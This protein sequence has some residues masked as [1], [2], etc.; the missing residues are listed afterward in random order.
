[1]NIVVNTL[2]RFQIA[3]EQGSI[4]DKNIRSDMLKKLLLYLLLHRDHPLTVQELCA[5]LWQEDEI[6]N[7][8]G[9]LKNLMYRLRN[10]L[11][12]ELG[13]SDYLLSKKGFYSWNSEIN[14]IMDCEEFEKNLETARRPDLEKEERLSY[15]EDAVAMYGGDF[16]LSSNDVFWILTLSTY[17]HSMYITSVKE[18]AQLYLDEGKFHQMELVCVEA[19][20]YEALDEQLNTLLVQSY[21]R[22]NKQAQ[23]KEAFEKV[24][25]ILYD[26]LGVRNTPLLTELSRELINMNNGETLSDINEMSSEITEEKVNGAYLCGYTV[27]REIYHLEARKIRRLGMSEYLVLF[28][29]AMDP[30]I[31]S[32]LGTDVAKDNM[33]RAK[34]I[35]EKVLCDTLRIGDVVS[36][37]SSTQYVVMLNSC[38]YE[39]SALVANRVLS[40]FYQASSKIKGLQVRMDVEE[41]IAASATVK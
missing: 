14:V 29:I 41:V 38:S 26:Q 30:Q 13:D 4:N 34:S 21:M 19:L 15:Y 36:R 39:N 16:M 23:A 40:R 6:D 5:A 11:K 31:Y 2:G 9:A 7:P 24:E 18:M 22:Q 20:H 10:L 28:T 35:L 33:Q 32:R 8:S 17:Y 25:K 37:Y 27:F 1:M 12:T 3:N